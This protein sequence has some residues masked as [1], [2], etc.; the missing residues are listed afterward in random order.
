MI[1]EARDASSSLYPQNI[2]ARAPPQHSPDTP[3][4]TIASSGAPA[5]IPVTTSPTVP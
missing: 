5:G 1:A 3:A 2:I 4:E